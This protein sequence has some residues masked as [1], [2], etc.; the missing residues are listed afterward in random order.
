MNGVQTC[1]LQ[2]CMN[3]IQNKTLLDITCTEF[4]LNLK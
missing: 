3:Y 1:L 2:Y 4:S